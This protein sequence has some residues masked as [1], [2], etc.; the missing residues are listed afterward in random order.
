MMITG[1]EI[2]IVFVGNIDVNLY[3]LAKENT[4]RQLAV[5]AISHFYFHNMSARLFTSFLVI[6]VFLLSRTGKIN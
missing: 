4:C 2:L 5:V 3:C 6:G 1:C